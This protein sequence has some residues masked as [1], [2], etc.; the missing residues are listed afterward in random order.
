MASWQKW[1]VSYL[2]AR[3]RSLT[4]PLTVDV[5]SK[6]HVC[7]NNSKHVVVKGD[8]RL[9]VSV[10]RSYEHYCVECA[11]KFIKQAIERLE[12]L[13]TQLRKSVDG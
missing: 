12:E 5:A 10:G 11:R 7:Q 4:L 8:L 2:M 3:P 1:K 13:D 9:K 6:L